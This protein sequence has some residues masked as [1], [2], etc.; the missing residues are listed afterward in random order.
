MR[1]AIYARYGTENQRPE[2]IDDQ[3]SSCRKYAIE[4]GWILDDNLIFSDSAVSGARE[5]R[6]GLREM[7][8][9]ARDNKFDAL[10]VDDLSRLARDN[11]LMLTTI[12]DLRFHGVRVVS[13]ADN[14]NS[15][16][17]RWHR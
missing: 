9:H 10:L 15:D 7:M 12:A 8:V 14:L 3:V 11:L 16:V 1:V 2:S 17:D 4:R 5:D 6:L 13:V